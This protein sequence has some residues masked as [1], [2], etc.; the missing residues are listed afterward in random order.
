M[1]TG[2]GS[3]GRMEQPLW[4]LFSFVDQLLSESEYLT[5]GLA[6]DEQIYRMLALSLLRIEGKLESIQ[7]YQKEPT[8]NWTNRLDEL[9]DYIRHNAHK[10]LTLT[11]LEEQ[12]NYSGRHLQ[13]I[14]KDKFECSPMDFVRRQR[15]FAAMEKLQTANLGETVTTIARDIGY[16]YTPNFTRD[17]QR[18]FGVKPSA[19]LRSTQWRAV[20][21]A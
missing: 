2:E 19:V 18:E 8:N 3:I 17:F 21:S 12:S 11:D 7:N 10:N 5:A 9:V 1:L 15:L 20:D 6:L 13:N 4:S 16:R 14:F